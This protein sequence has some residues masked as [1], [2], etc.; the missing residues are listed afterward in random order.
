MA[1]RFRSIPDVLGWACFEEAVTK[2]LRS[3]QDAVGAQASPMAVLVQPQLRA[4]CGGVM[5]GVDPV[6]GDQRRI[7]VEAVAGTPDVLVSGRVT[8]ARFVLSRRGRVVEADEGAAIRLDRRRRRALVR[9]ARAAGRAF[10]C[11]QDVEWAFDGSLF[12]GSR[13][14]SAGSRF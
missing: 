9:L 13:R 4:V 6:T 14:G 12:R 1:G 8:A 2:V 3:V 5:F 10:G 7:V 11:P